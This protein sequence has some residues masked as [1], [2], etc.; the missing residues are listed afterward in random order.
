MAEN[1]NN[2]ILLLFIYNNNIRMIEQYKV[3]LG[4]FAIVVLC[5]GKLLKDYF[6]QN[7]YI[8]GLTIDSVSS[9]SQP[10]RRPPTSATSDLLGVSL[11]FTITTAALIP[12]S[13]TLSLS[14]VASQLAS[15]G[16]VL[17]SALT[18]SNCVATVISTTPAADKPVSSFNVTSSGTTVTF[19]PV[20]SVASVD[21]TKTPQIAS[22][23]QL[24]FVISGITIKK[25]DSTTSL[26]ASVNATFT[27]TGVSTDSKT[28]NVTV[29]PPIVIGVAGSSSSTSDIEAALT[30]LE[31][32]IALTPTSDPS[33]ATLTDAKRALIN[34]LTNTYGTVAGAS[35]VFSSGSLYDAQKT[36]LDFIGKEKSRTSQNANILET[37][38]NN[39]KRM[40]QIN[41]YYTQNYQ[42]NTEIMKNIIYMSVGLIVLTL[43]K[44]KEYIPSSIATL[45]TIFIL[46][47]GSI[48]IGQKIFDILR[49]NDMDFDKYDWTFD[50]KKIDTARMT[51][52]NANP[53]DL[54]A[55]GAMNAQ[56]P[57]YGP[58]CCDTGTTWY[59]KGRKC[60]TTAAATAAVAADTAA[61]SGA[62]SG[63]A[64]SG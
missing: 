16:I 43:L 27:I 13:G 62:A 30:K 37:D 54:S 40:S 39:K 26:T 50:E 18:S 8:E 52:T 45:G 6:Y 14:W 38:N 59:E 64:S 48:V 5:S 22:G 44:T 47:L 35:T 21:A 23:T 2:Q 32:T 41:M 20:F 61:A 51:Q 63:A 1:V 25:A 29:D 42:A 56:A 36:A 15:A 3:L 19:T 9:S 10:L 4:L 53:A 33:Y 24:R 58:G 17:P 49:R 31:S 57:C 12:S 46:V 60:M 34:I 7:Q 28:V 11:T 55:L